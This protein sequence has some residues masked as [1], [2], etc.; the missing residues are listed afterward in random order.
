MLKFLVFVVL[1]LTVYAI[2][3]IAQI[4]KLTKSLKGNKPQLIT[5]AKH[6]LE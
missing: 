6:S 3:L 4:Y 2:R 1:I 5:E